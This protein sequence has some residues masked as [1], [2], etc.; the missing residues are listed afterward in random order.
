MKDCLSAQNK[1]LQQ[2]NQKIRH[3]SELCANA[4]N[5]EKKNETVP[6][7][8]LADPKAIGDAMEVELSSNAEVIKKIWQMYS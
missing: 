7:E 1:K 8:D 5:K 4:E 3:E 6:K 2:E